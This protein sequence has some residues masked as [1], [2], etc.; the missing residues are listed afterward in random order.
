M[1]TNLVCTSKALLPAQSQKELQFFSTWN[2]VGRAGRGCH[3]W[4]L[5]ILLMKD[6]GRMWHMRKGN[7]WLPSALARSPDPTVMAKPS[8]V[9][10]QASPGMGKSHTSTERQIWGLI[11][12]NYTFHCQTGSCSLLTSNLKPVCFATCSSLKFVACPKLDI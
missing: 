4:A 12:K 7:S 9:W 5:L 8:S 10:L 1:A 6:P 11:I 2:G 3:Y